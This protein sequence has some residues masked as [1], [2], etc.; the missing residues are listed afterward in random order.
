MHSTI[1]LILFF[2]WSSIPHLF[3]CPQ[4]GDFN[5]FGSFHRTEVVRLYF[6]F[7]RKRENSSSQIILDVRSGFETSFPR[8]VEW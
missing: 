5:Y 1:S 4:K 8:Q 7:R 3:H 6:F 2:Q